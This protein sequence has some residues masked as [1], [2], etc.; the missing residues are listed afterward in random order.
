[1]ETIELGDDVTRPPGI[2]L[3][4]PGDTV[5]VAIIDQAVIPWTEFGTGE[6]KIG[7]NGKP[8]TQE[9]YTAL[10]IHGDA[11]RREGDDEVR[12]TPGEVVSIYLAG[13]R[14]WNRIEAYKALG[15][16]VRVGDVWSW[17]YEKDERSAVAGQNPKKVHS[18]IARD[19]DDREYQQ[20]QR[21]ISLYHERQASGPAPDAG[22]SYGDEE[23]F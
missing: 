20:T 1:M 16:K 19:A 12:V 7:K 2:K 22:P 13:H 18:L 8:R 9:V 23:P 15:R 10:V 21:C 5:E 17:T 6:Q 14:R 3:L 11:V 4:H